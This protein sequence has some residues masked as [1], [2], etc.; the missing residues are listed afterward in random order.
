VSNVDL[1]IDLTPQSGMDLRGLAK[2]TG[3]PFIQNVIPRNGEMLVRAGLGTLRQFGTSLNGGRSLLQTSVKTGIGKPIGF[4]TVN[5]SWGAVQLL[6]IHPLLAFTGDCARDSDFNP[7]YGRRAQ[8]IAGV[9]A[10]V[11]D[12]TS[13]RSAEFVLH[14]QDAKTENLS[15]WL[16]NYATRYDADHSN[17]AKPAAVP[18]W[19]VFAQL[20]TGFGGLPQRNVVVCIDQ[21]GLWTYRPVDIAGKTSRQNDSLDRPTLPPNVGEQSAFSP[22]SLFDG[23]V[24]PEMGVAYLRDLDLGTVDA[25]AVFNGD[26]IVYGSRNTLWF[27]DPFAAG[28]ILADQ[29]YALPTLDTITMISP[30]RGGIV[31]S[32]NRQT[33]FYQPALAGNQDS[34]QLTLLSDAIGCVNNRAYVHGDDGVFFTDGRGIYAYNGGVQLVKISKP[35]DRLWSDPQSLQLPLTDF[36]TSD[37][38]SALTD[39]QL[40]ARIDVREQMQNAR[41]CWSEAQSTL[42][43]VGDDVTLCYTEDFGWSVW[44]FQTHAGDSRE[45][46]G[47]A[48]ITNPMMAASGN[49]LYLVGGP[50]EVVYMVDSWIDSSCYLLHLGRGGAI[51]RST[52]AESAQPDVYTSA[53]SGYIVPGDKVRYSVGATNYDYLMLEGDTLASIYTAIATL[54]AADPDYTVLANDTNLCAIA[55]STAAAAPVVTTIILTGDGIFTTTQT[56]AYSQ[57]NL[58]D[59]DLEDQRTPIGGWVKIDPGGNPSLTLFLGE[60]IKAPVG[61]SLPW[62]GVTLTEE[63]YWFPIMVGNC[64]SPPNQWRLYF[65]FSD[66]WV[67]VCVDVPNGDPA[68][69]EMAFITPAERVASDSGYLRGTPDVTHQVRV[70]RAGALDPAGNQIRIDFDGA[71]GT[72]STAPVIN[73]G[74]VGPDVLMYI[75]FRYSG[76]T[77]ATLTSAASLYPTSINAQVGR[78]AACLYHWESGRYPVEQEQWV[79]KQQPVDWAV[80][81]VEKEGGNGAQVR[82]RGVVLTAMHLGDGTVDVIPNWRYGPLNT[83]TSTDMRDYSGQALD[84]YSEPPGNSEQ[85]TIGPFPRMTPSGVT[86]DPTTKT[87]GN[88]ATWGDATDS[89]KGNLLIDDAAVDELATTDGSQGAR[90]SVMVHGTMNSPGESVRLGRIA[91]VLRK[92]GNLQRWR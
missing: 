37:G 12:V 63:T 24:T 55:Q 61:F 40:P 27:S 21:L 8:V 67:P 16:P 9:V 79:N 69:A 5:T 7:I 26:R 51:D 75:G 88:V 64:A 49:D 28:N 71:G 59:A 78:T 73:A 1:T 23:P 56:Q 81:S 70:Y 6:S 90:V 33:W 65:N 4:A 35:I 19:A 54:A 13:G 32:T 74:V 76:Q 31:V 11:H 36:Y 45:V 18:Q 89:T 38:F 57:S 29:N 25:L 91:A 50:D 17:W 84:F 85:N 87:A 30:V 47:L 34:G 68:Y 62:A 3:S 77:G 60:Y 48:N 44:L 82:C 39:D 41:L 92:M 66:T 86:T 15:E 80:K 72:W 22:L 20:G 10:I 83:A 2:N 14:Y 53:L 52:C 46:R 58:T 43:A 42:F